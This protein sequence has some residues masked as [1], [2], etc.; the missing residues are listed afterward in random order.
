MLGD[1]Q[2][3]MLVVGAWESVLKARTQSMKIKHVYRV[4]RDVAHAE[5][6]VKTAVLAVNRTYFL[7]MI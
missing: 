5:M 2:Y 4:I 3:V 7:Y 6:Q 1:F